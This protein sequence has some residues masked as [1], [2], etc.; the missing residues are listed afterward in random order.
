MRRIRAAIVGLGS[1][2]LAHLEAIRRLGYAELVAIVVRD[3][4]RARR[5][6]EFYG[7]PAYYADY[8]EMLAHAAVDVVH[9]CTPNPEHYPIN[10]AVIRSGRHILSEKP[11]TLDSG[12]SRELLRLVREAGVSHAVNFV[13]RHYAAVQQVRGMIEAGELGELYA[14]HG[15]YLQDWLLRESDYNWR[16]EARLG[17]PSRALAD[18]G[19]HWCDLAQFLAGQD[20]AELCA[21]LATFVPER[22]RPDSGAGASSVAVDTEDYG[23]VLLRFSGGVRGSFAVSQVSAGNKIGLSFQ[24]DGSR[25]S[26]RWSQ[27]QADRLWIGHRDAPNEELN[28]HPSLLNERGRGGELFSGRPERWPDAQKNMIDSFYRTIL[29]GEPP[30]YA[31]FSEGHAIMKVIDAALESHRSRSWQRVEPE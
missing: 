9:N 5:L 23:G 2:G 8:R 16:V 29:D 19:S 22:R 1:I 10:E 30:R 3:E 28:V 11:L 13:Y 24:I 4:A 14:I 6:C 31:D 25:A 12:Q 15:A 27:E 21:D 18:I 20:I 17:G 26:V 7:I